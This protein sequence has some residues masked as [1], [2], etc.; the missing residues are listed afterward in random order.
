[1]IYI[2]LY[3]IAIVIANIT[4]AVYGPSVSIINAFLFIGLDLTTRDKLHDAWRGRGLVWKMAL[5][6]AAGSAIS[7][8]LNRNAGPIALASF[9]AF[10]SAATIDA[11]AYH[12]LRNKSWFARVNGSNVLGAAVDSVIFPTL[13]FGGLLPWVTLGQFTAKVAGGALWSLVL[14][15]RSDV[16]RNAGL[17]TAPVVETEAT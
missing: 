5:L 4:V 15:G 12:L 10:A 11:G 3:L 16:V 2:L 8:L 14:R 1:M 13:A 9:V 7:W 6:I 17:G